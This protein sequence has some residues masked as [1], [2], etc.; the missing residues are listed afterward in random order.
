[1]IQF[2]FILQQEQ[3]DGSHT[4]AAS[5]TSAPASSTIP[6][7]KH[8]KPPRPAS[9]APT[10]TSP[11]RAQHA[12]GTTSNQQDGTAP[13]RGKKRLLD[14]NWKDYLTASGNY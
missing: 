13:G 12:T 8:F 10:R 9:A 11:R 14:G 4:A 1:M 7:P 2:C 6:K 3:T 5:R